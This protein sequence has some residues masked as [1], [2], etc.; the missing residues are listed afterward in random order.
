[1][2][3]V[4]VISVANAVLTSSEGN[5]D[6]PKNN[7]GHFEIADLPSIVFWHTKGLN[8]APLRRAEVETTPT[9]LSTWEIVEIACVAAVS[10][11][12]ITVRAH[13]YRV[14]SSLRFRKPLLRF[15]ITIAVRCAY[16]VALLRCHSVEKFAFLR[17]CKSPVFSASRVQHVSDLHPKF[18]L[19]PHHMWKYGRHPISDG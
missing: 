13:N 8:S 19:R 6:S 10:K 15:S 9:T 12:V 16:V 14:K 11:S 1:M 3:N 7:T 18:A 17:F 2:V 4:D 5:N